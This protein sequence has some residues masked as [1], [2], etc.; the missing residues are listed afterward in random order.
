[1]KVNSKIHGIIDYLVVLFLWSSPTLFSL[2]ETTSTFTYVLGGIHLVLT[3]LT[4]FELGL[5]KVIPLRI[6]GLIEL[7][8]SIV[9]I[10][11]AFIL[12]NKEGQIARNFYIAFGVAVFLTWLITDYKK[13]KS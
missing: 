3:V 12:G 1:M 5:I 4:K 7:I 13:D 11:I 8:V 9:L 2:P 6:H 10:L